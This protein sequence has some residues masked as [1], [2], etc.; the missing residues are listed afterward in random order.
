M[1][2]DKLSVY[3]SGHGRAS[4]KLMKEK[5]IKF[6]DKFEHGGNWCIGEKEFISHYEV[7][8][9]ISSHFNRELEI[10]SDACFSGNWPIQAKNYKHNFEKL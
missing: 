10:T 2:F 9:T 3:F 6:D 5:N 1:G 7:L 8:N 4:N